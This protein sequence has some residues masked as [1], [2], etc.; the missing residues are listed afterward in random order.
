[1]L[2]AVC[3]PH[4]GASNSDAERDATREESRQSRGGHFT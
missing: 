2:P 3:S 4:E 1:M